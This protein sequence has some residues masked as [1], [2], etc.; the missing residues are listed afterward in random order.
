MKDNDVLITL[1]WAMKFLT[2]KYRE[3]MVDWYGKRGINW[4]IAV[5]LLKT[6][7][8]YNASIQIC[9]ILS[10][11]MQERSWA[12]RALCGNRAHSTLYIFYLLKNHLNVTILKVSII[13]FSGVI[14]AIEP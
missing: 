7:A 3:G 5:S 10:R 2:R 4:H 6:S 1:D 9:K 8:G 13:S 14:Y 12:T 11:I